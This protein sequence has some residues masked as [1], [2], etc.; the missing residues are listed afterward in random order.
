MTVTE[1]MTAVTGE[2]V[3]VE[4]VIGAI[5]AVG[6]PTTTIVVITIMNPHRAT[7]TGI[8]ELVMTIGT[9]R[10]ATA[11]RENPTMNAKGTN[12]VV[13]GSGGREVL[14]EMMPLGLELEPD[15]LS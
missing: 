15:L 3:A 12:T 10:V 6:T 13:L 4:I 7:G 2:E 1:T 8:A 9:I 11:V 5:A 14:A